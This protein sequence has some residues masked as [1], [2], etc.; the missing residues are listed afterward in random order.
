MI[1]SI[2][3]LSGNI[4]FYEQQRNNAADAAFFLLQPFPIGVM[5]GTRILYGIFHNKVNYL[6][7]K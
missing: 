2:Y 6:I 5:Q 4:R 3:F 7:E 1:E